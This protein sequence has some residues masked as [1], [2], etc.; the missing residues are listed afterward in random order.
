M[1][2]ADLIPR[3]KLPRWVRCYEDMPARFSV[4]H[5][6]IV[7]GRIREYVFVV[8]L[9]GLVRFDEET[10]HQPHETRIDARPVSHIPP[11]VLIAAGVEAL[12]RTKGAS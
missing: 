12:R 2:L 7:P 4:F 9:N 1:K 3:A 10:E 5:G 6:T 11:A 8:D